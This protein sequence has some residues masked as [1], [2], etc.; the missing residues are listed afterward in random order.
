MTKMNIVMDNINVD[1]EEAKLLNA[2]IY[3][4]TLEKNTALAYEQSKFLLILLK[5]L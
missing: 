2:H 3:F 4:G 1:I 5:L